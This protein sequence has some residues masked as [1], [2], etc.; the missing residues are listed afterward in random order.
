MFGIHSKKDLLDYLMYFGGFAPVLRRDTA[1]NLNCRTFQAPTSV[2]LYNI[3]MN[4]VHVM[5][6]GLAVNITSRKEKKCL[7]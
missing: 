5:D 3:F 1:Q 6:H 7:L 4:K 2:G